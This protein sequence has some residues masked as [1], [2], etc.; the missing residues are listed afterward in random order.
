[1]ST[2][3]SKYN[4]GNFTYVKKTK[5]PKIENCTSRSWQI[6]STY[7]RHEKY[8][9][10]FNKT[11]VLFEK[12]SILWNASFFMYHITFHKIWTKWRYERTQKGS[13]PTNLLV[14]I[15]FRSHKIKYSISVR[16]EKDRISRTSKFTR[17]FEENFFK[18]FQRNT[19]SSL[20]T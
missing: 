11:H 12:S 20:I 7:K 18:Q 13:K 16:L 9:K 17:Y 19:N 5:S 15:N 3:K 6:C 1:M 10:I 4:T 14:S 2:H 8:P